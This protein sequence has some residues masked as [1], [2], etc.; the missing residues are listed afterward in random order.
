MPGRLFLTRP[1]VDLAVALGVDVPEDE[2]PPRHNIVPGQDLLVLTRAG[3][4]HMR[5]GMIPVGRKNARG[6]PV[7]DTIINVRG[8]TVFEK[9]AYAGTVRALIPVD[10]WYEWIGERRKKQTWCI[11]PKDGSFLTFAGITDVWTAPG[12]LTISQ[13]AV[14]TCPPSED[15][16]LL[17]H[18][19]GVVVAPEDRQMW[20]TGT[21]NEARAL[22]KSAPNN[23][24]RHKKADDVDWKAP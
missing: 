17:H 1:L 20:L 5:W 14:V 2:D 9:S 21:E 22:I 7:M 4:T 19:M 8:E 15:V 3:L 13:I 18:R 23:T 11:W 24:L 12:G 6:R 16:R 10:G